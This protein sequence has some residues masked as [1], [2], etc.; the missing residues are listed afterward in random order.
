MMDIPYAVVHHKIKIAISG[1]E[2]ERGTYA[3]NDTAF[4]AGEQAW[5]AAQA[6]K[7]EA[8]LLVLRAALALGELLFGK[9]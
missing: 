5:S 1:A 7:Y 6:A 8:V 2:Q 9:E 4:D 3:R